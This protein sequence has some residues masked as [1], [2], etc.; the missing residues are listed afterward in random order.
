[1]AGR[2]ADGDDM[3]I[4]IFYIG[5]GGVPSDIRAQVG[6]LRGQPLPEDAFLMEVVENDSLETG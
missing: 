3:V 1:M 2:Q 5:R 6:P 4:R